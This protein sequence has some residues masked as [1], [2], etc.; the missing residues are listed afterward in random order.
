[1]N[2]VD[3]LIEKYDVQ[4]AKPAAADKTI[5]AADA[6]A[7]GRSNATN[8]PSGAIGHTADRTAGAA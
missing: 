6:A 7:A 5:C 1:M 3:H 2:V 8:I 4:R